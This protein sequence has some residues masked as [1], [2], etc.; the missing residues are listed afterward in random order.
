MTIYNLNKQKDR[1]AYATALKPQP[2]K[3][4]LTESE[5][6]KLAYELKDL[7]SK[8]VDTFNFI[9]VDVLEAVAEK[10]GSSVIEHIRQDVITHEDIADHNGHYRDKKYITKLKK[11]FPDVEDCDDYQ[12]VLDQKQEANYPMWNTCFEFKQSES[13][14]VIQAAVDVGL[15]VIEGL[16]DFN[17]ILF[18]TSCG[19]S[20]YGSYWIPLFLKL[21]WN[22]ALAKKYEGVKYNMM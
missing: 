11:E 17:Q 13:E 1:N 5:N 12:S 9:Q 22:K 10:E 20:F 15:G 6:L 14:E 3:K 8:W 16:G 4:K 2:M 18:A 19:H 7:A 21:P